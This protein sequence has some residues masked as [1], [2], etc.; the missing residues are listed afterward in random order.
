MICK[1]E[2]MRDIQLQSVNVVGNRIDYHYRASEELSNY[3]LEKAMFVEYSTCV[4]A[5]PKSLLVI[6]FVANVLPVIW[7]TNSVLWI[8][9]IDR[10]FYDC[11]HRL[12]SAFQDLY[13]KAKLG[14][15]LVAAK[16]IENTY[17]P[18]REA[19]LL[20][21]GGID[22]HVS[23]LRL[24]NEKPLLLNIQGWYR[25]TPD[26]EQC[27]VAEID[28][29]DIGEFAKQ[30]SVEF[31]F[32]KSNFAVFVN[33]NLFNKK[34]HRILGDSLWHGFQH[35]MNF[36]TIAMPIA[37]IKGIRSIYIASSF[38]L[39][40]YG[41]CASYPTT[42]NEFKFAQN[43]R[44]VHDAFEMSRQEK[45]HYLVNYQKKSG[46]PYPVRVCSFNDSNCCECDKCFRSILEIVAEN[47]DIMNFGFNIQGNLKEYYS[48]VM[49][50]KI[51]QFGVV[52][53]SKK[54]WPDSI[55]RMKQNYDNLDQ[56]EFVDWFLNFDFIRKRK[57]AIYQYYY[58]NFFRIIKRKLFGR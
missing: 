24:R 14:G 48:D 23:Y 8:E 36:I 13:P 32:V 4:E 28:R 38:S 3:F 20:F 17:T 30:Q 21:S 53:E 10:T 45:V 9:E 5:V 52:G 37:Y 33:A 51:I 27:R 43:G 40:H 6:P 50:K 35:S 25:S 29:M 46:K 11:L 49:E 15:R 18:S 16:L 47:G 55:E 1:G 34:F 26:T 31:E 44:C 39:G 42:D 7:M 57:K 58:R 41:Q 22:A 56:K 54:H 2:K 12:K 19:L